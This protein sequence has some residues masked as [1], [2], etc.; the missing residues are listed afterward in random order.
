MSAGGNLA[1]LSVCML[2]DI[3]RCYQGPKWVPKRIE[4]S[5]RS[6]ARRR[7]LEDYFGVPVLNDKPAIAIVFSR[8]LLGAA[9]I[10]RSS[11][12]KTVS[13]A[14]VKRQGTKLPPDFIGTAAHVVHQRLL[15]GRTDLDGAAAKLGI[16]PRTFQRRLSVDG[17]SYN[18]LL[19]KC[20]K[21]RAADLLAQNE[22]SV[23]DIGGRAWLFV[24][25]PIYARV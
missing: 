6:G 1:T 7:D 11:L 24:A 2:I 25:D 17:V 15:L 12:P 23:A 9:Q 8:D 21:S 4:V 14:D 10:H 18:R 16:G 19:S 20:L 5:N 22:L 13:R 3:V